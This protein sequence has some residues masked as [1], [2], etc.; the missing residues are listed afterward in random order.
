MATKHGGTNQ[1]TDLISRYY[2]QKCYAEDMK[3]ELGSILV[4]RTK[5][6]LTSQ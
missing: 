3:W 2:S 6:I 1:C 5:I 4:E